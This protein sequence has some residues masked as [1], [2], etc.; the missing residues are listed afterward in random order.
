[1]M[2]IVIDDDIIKITLI[3]IYDKKLN[4][5]KNYKTNNNGRARSN[6]NNR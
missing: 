2:I 3:N 1:M 4:I 6:I 5:Y